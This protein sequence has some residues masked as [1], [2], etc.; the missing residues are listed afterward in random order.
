MA[1]ANLSDIKNL[2]AIRFI[3][4][5]AKWRKQLFIVGIVS[6]IASYLLTFLITPL[7]KSTTIVY[8]FNL[9]VYSKESATEQMVQLLKSEDVR[10]RL[11][12]SFDLYNHYDIETSGSSPRFK[13]MKQ[14]DENINI[15]KTEYESVDISVLD[16]DPNIAARM[17]DSMI[18][19]MD[20][21]ALALMREK[22]AE[23]VSVFGDQMKASKLEMDSMVQVLT[24]L[25][26][27]YGVLDYENQ[28]LGFTREYYQSIANGSSSA[29]MEQTR[30]NLEEKGNEAFSLKENLWRVRGQ[31]NDIKKIYDQEKSNL[32]KTIT[33]HNLVTKAVSAEKKD[34]PKRTLLA[35]LL[36]L[37]VMVL[38]ILVIIYQEYY[39]NRF[40]KELSEE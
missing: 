1:S 34:S 28:V 38:A 36:T 26:T 10:E 29:R 31:Y 4:M 24:S 25:S 13:I 3:K 16:A 8:P 33:F 35:L 30:R 14:L 40:E 22:A 11:I 39:K 27:Q 15:N 2:N 9:N 23:N 6:G 18:A 17:C 20:N 7:Y 37:S 5:L 32:T 21:K 12:Q 19:F